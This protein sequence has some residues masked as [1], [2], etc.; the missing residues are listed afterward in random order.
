LGS[1]WVSL[2]KNP[3]L[4]A[5]YQTLCLF[6]SRPGRADVHRFLGT[7]FIFSFLNFFPP[8]FPFVGGDSLQRTRTLQN[9]AERLVPPSEFFFPFSLLLLKFLKLLAGPPLLQVAEGSNCTNQAFF[10]LSRQ[11]LLLPTPPPDSS[12]LP[13]FSLFLPDV[14]L[15]NLELTIGD[16]TPLN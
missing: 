9:W 3:S 2:T 5:K 14:L 7:V 10:C 13:I 11:L 6:L 4:W 12:P 1:S 8:P 15:L 16:G